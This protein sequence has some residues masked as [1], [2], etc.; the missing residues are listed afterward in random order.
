MKAAVVR[1]VVALVLFLSWIG[2]LAFLAVTTTRP[3]VLSRPQ[4][5]VSTLDVIAEVNAA[6]D[7]P[8]EEVLVKD[9]HWPAE[10]KALAGRRITVIDLPNG[11]GWMGPGMYI[12]P[13]V[14]EGEGYRL[15]TI[16]S[17]PG[18]DATLRGDRPR[19]YP[20]TPET[21]AQLDEIP[22]KAKP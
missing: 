15:A 7:H 22:K 12:L 21:L 17:S 5:L 16:P 13:L 14:K 6:G 1:L 10:E 18:Y 2:W 19:I 8:A 3:V 9:V 20:V 11:D 4:L